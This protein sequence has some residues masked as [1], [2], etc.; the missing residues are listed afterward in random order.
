MRKHADFGMVLNHNNECGVKQK[1]SKSE[2][3]NDGEQA[4]VRVGSEL[5]WNQIDWRQVQETVTRL[6]AR[7]VKA[8]QEGRY[9]KV[10]SLTR[11]LTRSFAA[12]AMAVKKVT[13]NKGN[14]TPGVDGTVW[15]SAESKTQAILELQQDGY[16]A[17][18]LRRKYIPKAG[19]NKMRPL[20]IPTMKDRAMQAIHATALRR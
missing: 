11:I 18:P 7:I 15:R 13:T 17:K 20:G 10:K 4:S 19:S 5:D 3:R 2:Q 9:G 14:H 12:K 16:R 1:M 8:Q 6:Q